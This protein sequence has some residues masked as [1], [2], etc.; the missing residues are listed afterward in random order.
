VT[1]VAVPGTKPKSED[2]RRNHVKPTHEWTEVPDE[3]YDGKVPVLPREVGWPALTRKW[4]KVISRMPHCRLW[5]EADW[6]FAIDTA[7]IAAA[8]HGGD[9]RQATELRQREKILG[10]TADARR[11]L[12]IRY[13]TTGDRPAAPVLEIAKDPRARLRSAADEAPS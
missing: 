7:I 13:V 10:T 9:L 4:W 3:P 2:Q 12:R 6:Q 8:F 11:D 5:S 1:F